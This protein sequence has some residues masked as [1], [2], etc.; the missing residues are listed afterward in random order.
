MNLVDLPLPFLLAIDFG[1]IF[2]T[3]QFLG[4]SCI[5][6]ELLWEGFFQGRDGALLLLAFLTVDAHAVKGQC[7]I[8]ACDLFPG[9]IL[10]YNKIFDPLPVI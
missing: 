2:G 4:L 10:S 6:F 9:W 8:F 7:R 1:A 3:V 5:W